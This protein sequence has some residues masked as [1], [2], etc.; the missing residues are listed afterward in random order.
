[1]YPFV[2]C[3]STAGCHAI[4]T[5]NVVGSLNPSQQTEQ[6][7]RRTTLFIHRIRTD[8]R[9][10][11]TSSLSAASNQINRTKRNWDNLLPS[12]SSSSSITAAVAIALQNCSS[13]CFDSVAVFDLSLG[14]M[15]IYDYHPTKPKS[16]IWGFRHHKVAVETKQ[17][18]LTATFLSPRPQRGGFA[19][20]L[21]S[22]RSLVK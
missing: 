17:S 2:K 7:R 16:N 15:I 3:G 13:L 6:D 11:T 12:T 22:R 14:H 9:K 21:K 1:M 20:K 19:Y 4:P 10:F 5:D 18:E 8:H